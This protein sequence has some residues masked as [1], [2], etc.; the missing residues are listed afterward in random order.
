MYIKYDMEEPLAITPSPLKF[1]ISIFC[2]Y[3]YYYYKIMVNRT[4]NENNVIV[5]C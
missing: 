5:S 3:Y 1:V 2:Y 4:F